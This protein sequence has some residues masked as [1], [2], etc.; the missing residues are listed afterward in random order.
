MSNIKVKYMGR[1]KKLM[2][3]SEEV[4]KISESMKAYDFVKNILCGVNNILS[5]Y[6]F[7]IDGEILP[8]ILIFHGDDRVAKNSS[9]ILQN[10]DTIT[11]MSAIAG[12]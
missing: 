4:I 5:D 6:L 7:D 3:V 10:N 9:T 1:I 12:G 2:N 11:I 8:M